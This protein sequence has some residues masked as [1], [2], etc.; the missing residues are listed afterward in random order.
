MPKVSFQYRYGR[1]SKNIV[2]IKKNTLS[3]FM[4]Y[5][6]MWYWVHFHWEQDQCTFQSDSGA[7]TSNEIIQLPTT[8]P[9]LKCAVKPCSLSAKACCLITAFACHHYIDK[10]T[11]ILQEVWLISRPNVTLQPHQSFNTAEGTSDTSTVFVCSPKCAT[12]SCI[13]TMH[14]VE[15]LTSMFHGKIQIKRHWIMKDF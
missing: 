6:W 7:F 8:I 14:W 3:S 15:I 10:L 13:H 11:A 9:D 5:W 12:D 4:L 1:L 2:S